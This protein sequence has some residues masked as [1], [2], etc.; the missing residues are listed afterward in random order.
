[1]LKPEWIPTPLVEA[2][3]A[4]RITIVSQAAPIG[5]VRLAWKIARFAAGYAWDTSVRRTPADTRAVALRR[6]V[7]SLGGMWVK[8][9]QLLSLRTDIFSKELV[10]QLSLL[11]YRSFGFDPV[12]ARRM[13]EAEIGHPI[14][15]V[16]ATFEDHPFAAASIS[17]IHH[18][19]LPDGARV[20][21]KIQR[22]GIERVLARDLTFIG[23]M[24]R[25]AGSMP[26]VDFIDWEGMIRELHRM[27]NE[28]VDYRHEVAN[29][30]RMRK[31]LRAHKVVVPKVYERLCSQRVIVMEYIEG[32]VM[33]DYIRL[34][35]AD[36][37]RVRAWQDA[38]DVNPVKVGSRLMRSFY[39]QVL[40]D[41]LFHGDLHPGNIILL[42][43][44]RFAL[45]DFGT[46]G[47]LDIRFVKL[48]RQQAL[49]FATG[50][51]SRA[52]DAYLLLA[53]SIPAFDLDAYRA[54]FT[55][56]AREWESRT[57]LKGVSYLE[58]SMTGGVANA[59]ADI[60]QRYRV[61]LS[62]Q[63]LRVGRSISTMDA[64]LSSLLGN[65]NPSR[66]LRS[67]LLQERRRAMRS[68]LKNGLAQV[69]TAV[70][71]LSDTYGYIADSLRRQAI[72]MKGM[73]SRG[74]SIARALTRT[75]YNAAALAV[76]G[77]LVTLFW[78]EDRYEATLLGELHDLLQARPWEMGILG[79]ISAVLLLRLRSELLTIFDRPVDRHSGSDR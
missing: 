16:F 3:G 73:A 21:V 13:I 44:S 38:N 32:V 19:T 56:A 11:Q 34:M 68:L 6:F 55:E 71:E 72:P 28:E 20:V 61:N 40:E 7:E 41:N 8:A 31:L 45:I 47:N 14:S 62:W 26:K 12:T 24:L 78:F 52:I 74:M 49:A 59:L 22:P 64:N 48:Y 63:F 60:N 5:S 18:A 17:Q 4:S 69:G 10:D 27:F 79:A 39:R 51:Y 65:K 33:S 57:H 75:A 42:K 2:S 15:D 25:R 50:D 37:E 58:R 66:I 43:N 53:D 35:R 77:V 9:G 30:R 54:E 36:P 67:Y 76:V 46:I 70:M 1:M 23:W 29:L